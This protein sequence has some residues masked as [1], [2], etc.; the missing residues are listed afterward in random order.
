[1]LRSVL[2]DGMLDA[3]TEAANKGGKTSN[4]KFRASLVR[5]MVLKCN[6]KN[7]AIDPASGNPYLDLRDDATL[8]KLPA[9]FLAWLAGEINRCDGSVAGVSQVEIG[10][11]MVTFRAAVGLLD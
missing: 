9:P 10:G 6:V 3:A 5:Q 2:T 1:V 7:R 11:V 4:A 8:A